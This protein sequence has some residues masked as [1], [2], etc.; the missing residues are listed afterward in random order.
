MQSAATAILPVAAVA[1]DIPLELLVMVEQ[2]VAGTCAVVFK[3]PSYAV[4][5]PTAS[6]DAKTLKPGIDKLVDKWL[7]TVGPWALELSVAFAIGTI[8]FRQ[9]KAGKELKPEKAVQ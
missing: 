5:L 8:A 4:D 2:T 9:F 1:S 3:N 6:G 7:P